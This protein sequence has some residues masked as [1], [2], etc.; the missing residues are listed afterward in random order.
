MTLRKVSPLANIMWSTGASSM[1]A[2]LDIFKLALIT[3]FLS[4]AELGV[5]AVLSVVLGFSQL[6]SEGGLANAIISREQLPHS[7]LGQLFNLNF[8][9]AMI[10]VTIAIAL[11]PAVSNFYEM[12]QLQTLIPL[13]LVGLPFSA[14]NRYY[15]A[16]L[17]QHL[18]MRRIGLGIV[19][20]KLL[21]L[22]V[23]LILCLL[24]F[25]IYA[26]VYASL[27]T[28]FAL[29]LLFGIPASKHIQYQRVMVYSEIKSFLSFSAIQLGDQLLNFFSKNF[30]ILLITKLL[31]TET[32]GLYHVSK[33][34]LMRAGEVIVQS[35]SRY[36]H[37]LLARQRIHD[38]PEF[39]KTYLKFFRGVTMISV[40]VYG[41]LA[42]NHSWFIQLVFGESYQQIGTLFVA[43]CVWLGLRFSTAPIATLWL[44]KQKPEYGL[45]WNASIAIAIPVLIYLTHTAGNVGIVLALAG[46]QAIIMLFAIALSVVL[47]S[48]R[49]WVLMQ[50]LAWVLVLA[51]LSCLCAWGLVTLENVAVKLVFSAATALVSL[52]AAYTHR[53][54]LFLN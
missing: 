11:A 9:L 45:F 50:Q 36:F 24:E 33:S 34:L 3:Y 8:V 18:M 7:I 37:P 46:L 19:I 53:N 31:G 1:S 38:K 41:L 44:V 35:L 12:P 52:W 47:C 15:Q 16:T 27:T 30:D 29:C 6:F 21:G 4:P 42:V 48:D 40:L 43:M 28:T 26:L 51:S 5:Y 13:I 10:V 32:A 14:I 23:T 2:L 54:R 17:Q 49:N 20:A 22:F 25:G 39:N